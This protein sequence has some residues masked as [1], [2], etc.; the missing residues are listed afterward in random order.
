[1][2]LRALLVVFATVLICPRAVAQ[3]GL[4]DSDRLLIAALEDYIPHA[5]RRH[6]TPGLNLA[7][8][9]RGEVIWEKGSYV[10]GGAGIT[11]GSENNKYV[12]FEVGAGTY[13]FEI[14]GVSPIE[15]E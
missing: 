13:F 9:R 6:Q 1:M 5:M 8:A 3:E 15:P 12:T 2:L 14:S 11:S 7:L 4:T 10:A